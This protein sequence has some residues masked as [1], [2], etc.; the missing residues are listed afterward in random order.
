[1]AG[2]V[3]VSSSGDNE[4]VGVFS[5]VGADLGVGDRVYPWGYE[6]RYETKRFQADVVGSERAGLF[7]SPQLTNLNMRLIASAQQ[8]NRLLL[9]QADRRLCGAA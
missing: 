5:F 3:D 1:M 6:A 4:E 8:P 9:R 7:R 2:F